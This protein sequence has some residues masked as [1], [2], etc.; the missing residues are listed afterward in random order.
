MRIGILKETKHPIDNRV[1][2]TPKQI[3]ELE[4]LYPDVSFEVQSSNI[5]AYSDE[6]YSRLNIPVVDRL[7]GCDILFGIKEADIKTLIP[8]KHYF[9]FGHIAKL[10]EYN[11]P[12]LKAMLDK[13]L[14]FSDYEYITDDSGK[15]LC[16]F[17]WW[18]GV[19]GVYYT[20]RGYGLKYGLYE[21][22]KPDLRFTLNDLL[23]NLKSIQLPNIKII[24]TGTGRVSEGAQYVLNSI[25]VSR[26]DIDTYLATE[27]FDGITYAIADTKSLVKRKDG[28][29]FNRQDF[30]NNPELYTSDFMRFANVSDVLI[31]A[32]FW[33]A[34]DPV[35][36]SEEE[37]KSDGL[38][39]KM[40]GD[41]TCD[42]MGSIKSTLR[43]S[44]HDEPYYDYNPFTEKEEIAFS[45]PNN[46]SVMAVDTCPNALAL[47]ASS[48][49]GD[50]LIEHIIMPLLKGEQGDI[51]ERATIVNNGNIAPN[52]SYLNE[53]VKQR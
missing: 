3:K 51:I 48:Y 5:R 26:V 50:M 4:R 10:Q 29:E 24:L 40:I 14:T 45:S 53:F 32:H 38:S 20:L 22:P 6:E 41:I 11:R 18:A 31:S 35:Y 8:N 7:D 12:L 37:L 25:G 2:L 47:D 15:R 34:E 36:L 46:I 21:L 44:T 27:I 39:I 19:V 1:A 17:G 30:S 49:F 42:I 9:F 33:G 13:G 16:A 43:A 52:Y 28:R 23:E